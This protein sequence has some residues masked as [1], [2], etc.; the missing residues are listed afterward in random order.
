MAFLCRASLVSFTFS[1]IPVPEASRTTLVIQKG[2]D[3]TTLTPAAPAVQSCGPRG[4][5]PGSVAFL[6]FAVGQVERHEPRDERRRED[7]P[8]DRLHVRQAAREL[9]HGCEVAVPGG[10]NSGE[11]GVRLLGRLRPPVGGL[12]ARALAGEAPVPVNE[13]N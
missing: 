7:L 10:R 1:P 12:T 3:S 4:G 6:P 2:G 8:E 13:S 9:V 5:A 11:A